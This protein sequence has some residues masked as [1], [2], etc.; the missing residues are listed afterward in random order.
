MKP[1]TALAIHSMILQSGDAPLVAAYKEELASRAEIK[2]GV[3][4]RNVRFA[5]EAD[6]GDYL[7]GEKTPLPQNLSDK[8]SA[9]GETGNVLTHNGKYINLLAL[10]AALPEAVVATYYTFDPDKAV[11]AFPGGRNAF[12]QRLKDIF[13]GTIGTPGTAEFAVLV[14]AKQDVFPLLKALGVDEVDGSW[15]VASAERIQQAHKY[16]HDSWEIRANQTL[17]VAFEKGVNPEDVYIISQ[18]DRPAA[19]RQILKMV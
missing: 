10:S 17:K 16:R 7:K 2:Q 1:T 3:F 9:L 6:G 12:Q 18:K 5:Y 11:D 8:I 4:L 14:D 15:D 19:V 13:K